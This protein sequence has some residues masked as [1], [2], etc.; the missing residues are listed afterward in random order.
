MVIVKAPKQIPSCARCGT[1]AKLTPIDDEGG[2][3]I[4]TPCYM[5]MVMSAGQQ[6]SAERQAQQAHDSRYDTMMYHGEPM[7]I[8]MQLLKGFRSKYDGNCKVCGQFIRAGTEVN[9]HPQGGIMHP[10]DC[11]RVYV[12]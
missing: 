11:G 2:Y 7:D 1:R 5:Q 8:A 3:H 9:M 4:C 10:Y 12:V 6:L